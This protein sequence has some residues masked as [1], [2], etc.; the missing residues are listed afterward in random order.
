MTARIEVPSKVFCIGFQKTA[1]SSLRDALRSLGYKVHGV[2]GAK[3][4]YEELKSCYVER[5]MAIAREHD[6]VEDMP[7]PLLFREL[8]ET[9]PGSK[10]ILSVRNTDSWYKSICGHF[11]DNFGPIERLTYGND[12]TGGAI[13]NKDRFCTTFEAHNAS[14]IDYFHGRPNDLLVVDIEAGDGWSELGA[15]LGRTDVPVGAF[16]HTNS[17]TDRRKFVNRIRSKLI[18]LGVP[19]TPLDG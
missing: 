11:Q 10:F 9:F 15:F 18:R 17:S 7:W 4:S 6:A 13:S 2:F 5:G 19:L 16:P 1:T 3:L 12:L 8:D 14:V